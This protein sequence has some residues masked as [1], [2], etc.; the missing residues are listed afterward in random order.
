MNIFM[1]RGTKS[2]EYKHKTIAL[3]LFYVPHVAKRPS[4]RSAL[5]HKNMNTYRFIYLK[6]LILAFKFKSSKFVIYPPDNYI[7]LLLNYTN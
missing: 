5:V 3:R 4:K 2:A 6:I 1:Q 7:T